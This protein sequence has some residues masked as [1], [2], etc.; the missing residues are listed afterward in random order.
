MTVRTCVT[1]QCK[2]QRD[3]C[4][5][6]SQAITK[7]TSAKTARYSAEPYKFTNHTERRLFPNANMELNHAHLEESKRFRTDA[8]NQ[9]PMVTLC[10]INSTATPYHRIL[11]RTKWELQ[12]T[13]RETDAHTLHRDC[14]HCT[15]HENNYH[16]ESNHLVSA[17]RHSRQCAS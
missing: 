15:M 1:Q 16:G 17:P 9:T 8:D 10:V 14:R 2:T 6:W 5:T 3:M 7:K 4:F 12:P 13:L 11:S